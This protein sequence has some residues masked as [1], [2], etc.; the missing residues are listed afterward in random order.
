MKL[1]SWLKAVWLGFS[2]L[3]CLALA[4]CAKKV[5]SQQTAQS[6]LDW[7]LKTLVTA[8]Q[9][10]GNT[11]AAWDGSAKLALAE[12]A[13]SRSGLLGTNEPSWEIMSTNAAAAVRAGC[14]DP[15]VNYLFIKYAMDQT[16]SPKAFADAF[17][18][19]AD[20]MRES[21]Y[22]NIRRFYA[23][24][25]AAE[26][27]KYAA[28][29]NP[30]YPPEVNLYR[31]QA[32]TN[33]ADVLADKTMP[34]GEVDDACHEM[35]RIVEVNQKQ[36]ED[37]YNLIEGS[38]FKNWPDESA[39]W[40]IKGEAFIKKA[41]FARGGD[42]A[43][44]VTDEG[45]RLFKENLEIAESSLNRAWKLNPKDPRIAVKMMW[46][47]LGQGQGRDRMELW[48]KRAMKLDP[49]DYDACSIKCLYLEPKWYGS[50]E[51]MLSFCREC[52][53]NKQWGGQVPLILVD[54]HWDVP[55]YYL[56]GPEKTNYWM[57]PEVWPDIKAAYDRYFELHPNAIVY[58][59]NYASYAYR[60]EQWDAL[61]EL[62][63]KL[64]PVNY[65]FFGGREEF[66]KMIQLAKEHAHQP[67]AA[68]QN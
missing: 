4:S 16:N 56:E 21:T 59:H 52:V 55:L 51:E 3:A 42:Y 33:L 34:I 9:Q 30:R 6:R 5:T 61:N 60:C 67:R 26:Q 12:F 10:A 63:P 2:L 22:P 15:M 41:W 44:K 18:K 29:G 54:A 50:I 39:I 27:L 40:L 1:P 35:F 20:N 58:Y 45:W 49:T 32:I 53:Q 8:Y 7:N 37:C 43:D 24:L 14:D 13:R 19:T 47:E 38:L 17:C 25:R 66:D 48:F 65:K 57:R 31:R 23:S 68:P 62:I 11:D 64:G 46:I 28:G 36:Y